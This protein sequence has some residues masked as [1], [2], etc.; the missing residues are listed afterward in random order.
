MTIGNG[1]WQLEL[2][3]LTRIQLRLLYMYFPKDK[4][5]C[6]LVNYWKWSRNIRSL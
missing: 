6:F 4:R 1:I 5:Y 3:F 2:T